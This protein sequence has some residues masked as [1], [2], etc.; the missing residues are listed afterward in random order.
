MLLR[1]LAQL[2]SP[3]LHEIG[4]DR[5][6][7]CGHGISPT[8]E[9]APFPPLRHG[10]AINIDMAYTITISHARGYISA[11]ERDQWFDLATA[12]GLSV[13]HEMFDEELLERAVQAIMKTRDGLQRFVLA[14]PLGKCVFANDISREEFA[15]T[16]AAHKAYVRE[17]YPITNGGQGVD[18][19]AD[20]G[21]LGADPEKMLKHKL[22]KGVPTNGTKPMTNG[23]KND[24]ITGREAV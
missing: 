17:R 13:D 6:I 23:V 19:Y 21:D 15:S 11:A 20:A 3:N 14:K 16:L 22:A 2:E 7:A 12:V 4:L 1:L 9:L 8:L 10:H 5:V 18:A 24:S